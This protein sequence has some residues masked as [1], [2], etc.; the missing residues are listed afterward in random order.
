[1]Q[2]KLTAGHLDWR[3]VA[4]LLAWQAQALPPTVSVRVP[5]PTPSGVEIGWTGSSPELRHTL[6]SRPALDGAP[7]EPVP[8][9]AWP[10]AVASFLDARPD[11]GSRFYR[12]VAE[13]GPVERGRLLQWTRTATLTRAE[14][15]FLFDLGGFPVTAVGDVHVYRVLYETVDAQRLRTRASGAVAVPVNRAGPLPLISYQHGTVLLREDVPSRANLEALIGVAFATDGYAAVLPDY[16]GLG[17]SP[18]VHPYHHAE[19]AASAV[20]D[21]VR[22]ARALALAEGIVLGPELFLAGYSQGGHATLAALREIEAHH[23]AEFPVTACAAGGGAYDL[24]GVMRLDFLSGR[25]RPN[26]FNL[27]YLL[28]GLRDVYGYPD[29]LASPYNSLLPPL[30]DGTHEPSEVNAV[31]PGSPVEVLRP[32]ARE[33]LASDPDHPFRAA[34]R[35]NDLLDWAPRAPLRLY[36][37]AGDRDVPAATATAARDAFATRGVAVPVLD[38]APAEGHVGCAVPTLL[39]IKAWFDTLRE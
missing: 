1:M 14:I 34:L 32:E 36:H 31:M 35:R 17:D 4:V 21:L 28:T 29:Y 18:G 20:L 19:S 22:A 39:A 3:V 16:V 25:P 13:P 37:C 9:T 33:A 7:W 38:P 6:E 11:A 30:L 12:V 15:Q 26:P 27:V 2:W 5:V 10:V 24:S 8:G 23:A